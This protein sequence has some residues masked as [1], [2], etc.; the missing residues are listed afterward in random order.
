MREAVP[1]RGG[2]SIFGSKTFCRSWPVAW[3]CSGRSQRRDVGREGTD[4][5]RGVVFELTRLAKVH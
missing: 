1:A 2:D 5:E 3:L 4:V